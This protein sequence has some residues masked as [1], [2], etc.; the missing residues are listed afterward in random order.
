ML[1]KIFQVFNYTGKTTLYCS[2]H[3]LKAIFYL[4]FSDLKELNGGQ[5]LIHQSL[6]KIKHDQSLF[7][8]II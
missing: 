1:L 3:S 7:L 4:K 8:P 5:T 6:I 2:W